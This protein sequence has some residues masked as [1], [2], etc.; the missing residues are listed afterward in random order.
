MNPLPSPPTDNL[1][2]FM[3][4]SGVWLMVFLLAFY[5]WLMNADYEI[6]AEAKELKAFITAQSSLR[7]IQA[8][9]ASVRAGHLGENRLVWIPKEWPIEQ[10]VHVLSEVASSHQQTVE[11][12]QKSNHNKYE[13]SLDRL[14]SMGSTWFLVSYVAAAFGLTYTGFALWY[15]RVQKPN[16]V[17]A[18]IELDI[19][20]TSLRK[21]E[22][23]RKQ[24]QRHRHPRKTL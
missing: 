21:V 14:S 12:Y 6:R 17:A 1:Y 13:E 5:A 23:E 20:N 24:I 15:R 8:R 10:E 9:L 11:T 16:E 19:K 7:N 3:A 22:P 2:K 18:R 4:L